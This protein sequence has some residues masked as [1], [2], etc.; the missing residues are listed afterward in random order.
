MSTHFCPVLFAALFLLE[1]TIG[2]HIQFLLLSALD[3]FFF[4]GGAKREKG[5][6]R[7][8][9]KSRTHRS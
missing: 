6:R 5:K 1:K 3:E 4:A 2:V 9:E 7:K 8:G